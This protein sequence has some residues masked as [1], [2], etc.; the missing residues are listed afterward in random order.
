MKPGLLQIFGAAAAL[1]C[2]AL[3]VGIVYWL[4]ASG[5]GRQ[6]DP[7]VLMPACGVVSGALAGLAIG[8][9]VRRPLLY[10]VIGAVCLWPFV[11][12]GVLSF[13]PVR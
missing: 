5:R 1:F 9:L 8:V 11:V 10:A 2:A 6:I 13:L 4:Y 3:G 12:I 7:L